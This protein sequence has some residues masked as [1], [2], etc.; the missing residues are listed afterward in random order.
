MAGN[1]KT[2]VEASLSS[3][4]VVGFVVVVLTSRKGWVD[5]WMS[6]EMTIL[7]ALDLWLSAFGKGVTWNSELRPVTTI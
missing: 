7:A 2:H 4:K 3:L 1:V 6:E 5:E